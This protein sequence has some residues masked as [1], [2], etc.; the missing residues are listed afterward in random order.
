MENPLTEAHEEIKHLEHL[1]RVA[2]ED[3]HHRDDPGRHDADDAG[4]GD[5]GDLVGQAFRGPAARQQATAA[6]LQASLDATA[7][8]ATSTSASTTSPKPLALGLPQRALAR[9]RQHHAGDRAAHPGRRGDQGAA[10]DQRP[11][12]ERSRRPELRGQ[13]APTGPRRRAT[14]QGARP[15]ERRLAG[16]EQQR[17]RRGQHAGALA[18]PARP[19]PDDRQ[20]ADPDRLH[21]RSPSS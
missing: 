7:Q 9:G 16:E 1:R 21:R 4:R 17:A 5:G 2:T 18:V 19:R 13:A 12:A 6:S 10:G 14:G 20:P 11:L 3:H 15:G 8:Q